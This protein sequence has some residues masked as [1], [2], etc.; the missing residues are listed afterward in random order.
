MNHPKSGSDI[1]VDQCF[2]VDQCE[3][4]IKIGNNWIEGTV[5]KFN[6][7]LTS[8]EH[9]SVLLSKDNLPEELIESLYFKLL[10][11][12]NRSFRYH[13]EGFELHD[14]P[15]IF[16]YSA[17]RQDHYEWHRDTLKNL[18]KGTVR[19]LSFSIQLSDPA[20]YDGG[21]LEFLPSLKDPAMR[22][23]GAIVVFPSYLTHRISKITQG[24]RYVIVGWIHGPEFR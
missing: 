8:R 3:E 2:T 14:L 23:Q 16:K 15:R 7:Q 12:N 20:N 5:Q 24:T 10:Q 19:K 13:L 18:E 4:I 6:T 11:I 22:R 17:D 1:I 9:R 21:D